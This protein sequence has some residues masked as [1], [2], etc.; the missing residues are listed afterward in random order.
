MSTNDG[1]YV[2][3]YAGHGSVGMSMRD[4]FAAHAPPVPSGWSDADCPDDPTQFITDLVDW[5]YFY[6]DAMIRQRDES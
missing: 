4:Y 2:F 5:R 6:A 1:G 3:P